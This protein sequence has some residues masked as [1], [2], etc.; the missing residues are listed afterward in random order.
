MELK[1]IG[2]GSK[3]NCYILENDKEALII[4]CGVN[5]QAIKQALNFNSSKVV[6]CI[7]SHE[8]MDHA[9]S[10]NDLIKSGINVYSSNG[11]FK[12][13]QIKN[14][15]AI[16]M[17]NKIVL[18]IGNFKVMPFDVQHDAL[19]PFGFIIKHKECG[20]VLFLTD[21]FYCAYTFNNINNI[22]IEANYSKKI[23]DAKVNAGASPEFLRNRI[24]KSHMSLENCLTTLSANDLSKVNNIVLIH[25]SDSNSNE[26]EFK[27]SVE[28]A[29][30]KSVTVANNGTSINFNKTP[31]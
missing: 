18:A 26:I 1:V 19:E 10:I 9:K 22:L 16:P 21:T 4:E 20:N 2:T 17:H 7:V 23:I 5:V 8:H 12:A 28:N 13:L 15:R 25:L 14:H 6:G 24:L 31:F 11:T 3:G 27:S 30:G 29:T